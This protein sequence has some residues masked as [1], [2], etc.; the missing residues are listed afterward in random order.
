MMFGKDGNHF[1]G[2]DLEETQEV[3]SVSKSKFA[4]ESFFH[5][6]DIAIEQRRPVGLGMPQCATYSFAR[7]HSRSLVTVC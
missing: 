4:D 5:L 6:G 3:F 1:A 7:I 2:I